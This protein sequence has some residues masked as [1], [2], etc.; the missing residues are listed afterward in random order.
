ML[1][2]DSERLLTRCGWI[3][4]HGDEVRDAQSFLRGVLKPMFMRGIDARMLIHDTLHM[5][6]RESRLRLNRARL[7]VLYKGDDFQT[8]TALSEQLF[9]RMRVNL[10]AVLISL[11]GE[12]SALALEQRA[13][14]LVEMADRIAS[15]GVRPEAMG[16]LKAAFLLEIA[17]LVDRPD[18]LMPRDVGDSIDHFY[19]QIARLRAHVANIDAPRRLSR[20]GIKWT[21][22]APG[23]RLGLLA[24]NNR[25]GPLRVN[26]LE[27]SPK[28][29]RL[30]VV[31]VHEAPPTGRNLAAVAEAHG[32][33]CATGGGFALESEHEAGDAARIGDPLGL[34]ISDGEVLWPPSIRRTALLMDDEGKVDIWRVGMMG[35]RLHIRGATVL[36]RKVDSGRLR[37][38]E[39]GVF[40][41][42]YGRPAPPAPLMISIVGHRVVEVASATEVDVPVG[43][44]VV[45]IDPGR[46]DPGA[47]ALVEPGDSVMYEMPA[48]RGLGHLRQAL[49]GG[50]ALLTNG[51]RDGDAIADNFGPGLPP[52]VYDP[53]TRTAMNLAARLGWGI[54][55]DHQL[56]AACVDGHQINR[57]VGLDL[58]D[59][60]R[61]LREVGCVN[62]V[63]FAGGANAR[64]FAAGR[65]VD[66]NHLSDLLPGDEANDDG[67]LASAILVVEREKP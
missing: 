55:E 52:S 26:F 7:N 63:N 44:L 22:L 6:Q 49:A 27:I 57:S 25:L 43:G 19:S 15:E 20:E 12:D 51:Q 1:F 41:S 3:A 54:T 18:W 42:A 35:V 38:G 23:L 56:I 11:T 2:R 10:Y 4:S 59:F 62:A 50:P 24:G 47:L 48:M 16:V 28:K 53:R 21:K 58:D 65:Y 13:L 64:M 14:T 46:A 40:T 5:L 45:A 33:A 31:D 66:A 36:V 8:L 17:D 29:W 67:R 30:K 37:T 39:I 34:L 9:E 32:A 60:G 61:L